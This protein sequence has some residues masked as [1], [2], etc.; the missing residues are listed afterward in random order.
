MKKKSS[1]V[2]LRKNSIHH[3]HTYVRLN[4]YSYLLVDTKRQK[5]SNKL[6]CQ[7]VYKRITLAHYYTSVTECIKDECRLAI[8]KKNALGSY[9][10]GTRSQGK[11]K[12]CAD[13]G[14]GCCDAAVHILSMTKKKGLP[15]ERKRTTFIR[16]VHKACVLF[17][18]PLH[19][20]VYRLC[21]YRLVCDPISS[22]K[23]LKL[24]HFDGNKDI[25]I[26][27]LMVF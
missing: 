10:G 18:S 6:T 26:Y 3:T 23:V 7:I 11:I 25:Y 14:K 13:H 2:E 5:H 17:M 1:V 24:I 12:L 15:L 4:T 19:R 27:E 22:E 16:R 21:W 8:E 20:F 9:L